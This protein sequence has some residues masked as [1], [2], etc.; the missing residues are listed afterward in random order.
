MEIAKKKKTFWALVGG[1]AFIFPYIF[2]FLK[3]TEKVVGWGGSIDF[4]IS[5]SEEPDWVGTVLEILL[6]PPLWLQFSF[7]LFAVS[8]FL[9][10]SIQRQIEERV[11]TTL[12]AEAIQS[13]IDGEGVVIDGG[14]FDTEAEERGLIYVGSA[15]VH[16]DRMT[17]ENRA[18]IAIIA[19]NGHD[20][21]VKIT[22]P[23]NHIRISYQTS[24]SETAEDSLSTPI[25]LTDRGPVVAAARSEFMIVL[26]QYLTSAQIAAINSGLDIAHVTF[27][28]L[29]LENDLESDGDR[30]AVFRVPFTRYPN[31]SLA[32]AGEYKNN[33]TI[34]AWASAV[35]GA[36]DSSPR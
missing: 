1:F 12:T 27:N 17:E 11:P 5:R 15:T 25:L 16:I 10:T 22:A 33:Y 14:T 28:L 9:S 3:W 19:F 7:L 8:K 23:R 18:E 26:H 34:F 6:N 31:V 30:G 36:P 4:L 20:F 29:N 13:V 32:K 2:P 24:E 35:I 21:P